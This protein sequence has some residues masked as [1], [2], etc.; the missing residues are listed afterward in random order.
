MTGLEITLEISLGT[1]GLKSNLADV[2]QDDH[3]KTVVAASTLL[4]PAAPAAKTSDAASAGPG[5]QLK[6]GSIR[7]SPTKVHI[8]MSA[9]VP[10]L[11]APKRKYG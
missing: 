10:G 2:M 9:G 6:I 11:L 3:S 8:R 1:G 5:K 7:L 4:L